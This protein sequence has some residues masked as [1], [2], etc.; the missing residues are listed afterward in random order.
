[1]LLIYY[2][3]L[4][5][6]SDETNF[7]FHGKVGA[8]KPSPRR[9]HRVLYDSVLER[10]CRVSGLWCVA[11]RS[12]RTKEDV[13]S[14]PMQHWQRGGIK[15]CGRLAPATGATFRRLFLDLASDERKQV[16]RLATST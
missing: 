7:N 9:C 13:F 2:R 6:R 16:G 11:L 15:Y 1:M 10:I 4:S 14:A 8:L 5:F 12:M 3:Y